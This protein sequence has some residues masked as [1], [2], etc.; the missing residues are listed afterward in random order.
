MV[1]TPPCVKWAASGNLLNSTESSPQCSVMT[2]KG[3]D[4][5]V[6]GREEGPK[7]R[8]YMYTYS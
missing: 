4:G 7:G 3:W 8:G 6:W 2:W 5:G 1:F